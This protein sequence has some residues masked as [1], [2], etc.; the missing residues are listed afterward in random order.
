[1][2]RASLDEARPKFYDLLNTPLMWHVIIVL[3]LHAV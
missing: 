3:I 1:M 2:D